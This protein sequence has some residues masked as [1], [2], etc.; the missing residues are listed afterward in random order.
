MAALYAWLGKLPPFRGLEQRIRR[1]PP[2]AALILF[3]VPSLSLAPVKFLALYWMAGGHPALGITA[4]A[5]AK[6]AGT[7]LVA[8]IYQLT[9][10]SLIRLPWFAWCEGRVLALRASA[11]E[12]WRSTAAGRLA[13]AAWKSSQSRVKAWREHWRSRR[14]TWL[15]L[16]WAAIRR[17]QTE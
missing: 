9:R 15:S 1:L 10:D 8:R 3:A 14:A 5:G 12:W 2:Y 16:R 11:Y 7:A 6:I 13:I 17:R 4:I